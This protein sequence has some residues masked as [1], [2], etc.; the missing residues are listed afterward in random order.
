M[1]HNFVGTMDVSYIV[2]VCQCIFYLLGE[3]SPVGFPIVCV[4]MSMLSQSEFGFG[5]MVII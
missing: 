1:C 4:A 5:I 3:C 2:G